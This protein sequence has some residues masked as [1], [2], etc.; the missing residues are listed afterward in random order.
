MAR[1]SA[2]S[3]SADIV[4]LL[5]D[6]HRQIRRAFRKA[7][8]PGAERP[9]RFGELVRLLAV[10]EAG[11]EAHVHPLVRH[12][13]PGGRQLAAERRQ[14]EKQAKKLLTALWKAGPQVAGYIGYA[15]YLN[16]LMALRRA[17]LTHAAREEREE[18]TALRQ[19]VSAPRRRLLGWEV[20]VTQAM[21]PT[22]PHRMVNNEVTNK[23]AAP[24]F[25]PLDRALDRIATMRREHG[26]GHGNG[27]AAE[28]LTSRLDVRLLSRLGG[29]HLVDGDHDYGRD[30]RYGFNRMLGR[31]RVSSHAH[32]IR[33]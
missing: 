10:H 8:M 1:S 26:D 20:R 6:Q 25:G 7:A 24:L 18:F 28:R 29:D 19:K 3:S 22:R 33:R 30:L 17:V 2:A 12:A 27:H 9:R 31:G 23:L 32:A 14:E 16:G 15:R 5:T 21:A 13:M 11:E 4:D